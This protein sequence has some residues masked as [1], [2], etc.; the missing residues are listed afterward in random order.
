MYYESCQGVV[1]MMLCLDVYVDSDMYSSVL[2]ECA[3]I[4][5]TF[6]MYYDFHNFFITFFLLRFVCGC[7]PC[8]GINQRNPYST[9]VHLFVCT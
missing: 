3:N 1:F 6:L 5:T 7:V 2:M 9:G 8:T 4:F